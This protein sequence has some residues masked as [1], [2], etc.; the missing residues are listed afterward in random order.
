MLT[1]RGEIK[2]LSGAEAWE[3]AWTAVANIDPEIETSIVKSLQPLP[4][5]VVESIKCMGLLPM[6]YGKEPVAVIRGQFLKVFEQLAARESRTGLLPASTKEAIAE[7]AGTQSRPRAVTALLNGIGEPN[8][9][10]KIGIFQDSQEA[11][12][13]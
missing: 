11:P 1:Q 4:A 6:C 7:I 12:Q 9:K 2:Q 13:T 3:L 10:N 5:L 8:A